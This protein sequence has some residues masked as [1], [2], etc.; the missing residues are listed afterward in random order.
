MIGIFTK[1]IHIRTGKVIAD[2]RT[3]ALAG[4]NATVASTD[5]A[6]VEALVKPRLPEATW[7]YWHDAAGVY[8]LCGKPEKAVEQLRRCAALG[9]PNY[10]LFERDP[11]LHG[12]LEFAGFQKLQTELRRGYD[13]LAREFGLAPVNP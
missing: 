12:L 11:H 2:A 8:T 1:L 6:V 3:A 10:R 7:R 13:E 4:E 9:L 5:A